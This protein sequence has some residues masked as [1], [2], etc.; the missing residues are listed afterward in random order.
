MLRVVSCLHAFYTPAGRQA[1]AP[2]AAALEMS[3][4]ERALYLRRQP[5]SKATSKVGVEVGVGAGAGDARQ[6]RNPP[7]YLQGVPLQR[8]PTT[9]DPT[10]WAR[11]PPSRPGAA[12]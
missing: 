3:P 10:L 11:L 4:Q 2:V 1:L 7:L 9:A 12:R 5:A 8:S 6:H